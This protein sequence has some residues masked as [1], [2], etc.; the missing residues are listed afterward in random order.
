MCSRLNSHARINLW[1]L[2]PG[3]QRLQTLKEISTA[4]SCK[5]RCYNPEDTA[6]FASM[7]VSDATESERSLQ[8][9]QDLERYFCLE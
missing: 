1:P 2:L 6:M 9:K 3:I 8:S 5:T 4:S 7:R